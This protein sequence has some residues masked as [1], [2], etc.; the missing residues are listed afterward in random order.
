MTGGSDAGA[1]VAARVLA[2][3]L[4][5]DLYRID[6]GAIASQYLGETAAQLDRVLDAAEQSGAVL[7]LDEADALLGRPSDV[8]DRHDRYADVEIDYLR[9]RIE[10]YRG[11]VILTIGRRR[12][13]DRAVPGRFDFV[14]RDR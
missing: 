11:L 12:R 14:I 13:L 4:G 1:L 7:L 10:K 3:M 2:G 9:Q 5:S 6:Q 8:K